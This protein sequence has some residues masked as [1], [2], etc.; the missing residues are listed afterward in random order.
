MRFHYGENLSDSIILAFRMGPAASGCRVFKSRV[1][2]LQEKNIPI[3]IH[4][5]NSKLEVYFRR[6][7]SHFLTR[8]LAT[9]NNSLLIS[10]SPRPVAAGPIRNAKIMES[11]LD[12]NL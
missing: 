5:G 4:I 2:K 12:H 8:D 3:I 10:Y 6:A 7:T 1:K 9:L 11:L